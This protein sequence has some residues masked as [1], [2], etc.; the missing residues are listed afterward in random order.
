MLTTVRHLTRGVC[1]RALRSNAYPQK[2]SLHGGLKRG[3]RESLYHFEVF[4][5]NH[6]WTHRRSVRRVPVYLAVLHF[7]EP[8]MPPS[9]RATFLEVTNENRYSC[10]KAG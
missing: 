2:W 7:L 9:M 1:R 6:R 8:L 10:R 3:T 4:T 5:I